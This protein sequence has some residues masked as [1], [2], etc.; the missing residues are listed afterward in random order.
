MLLTEHHHPLTSLITF[1]YL[2]PPTG[3][4]FFFFFF[5]CWRE[6]QARFPAEKHDLWKHNENGWVGW[7][8]GGGEGG[9]GRTEKRAPPLWL[10]V[11]GALTG[12]PGWGEKRT[13][14]SLSVT[15]EG[16]AVTGGR[17]KPDV[18]VQ[19]PLRT[20][21]EKV[22]SI[23]C[24]RRKKNIKYVIQI[25]WTTHGDL[26]PVDG[27]CRKS[28]VSSRASIKPF[29]CTCWRISH[30]KFYGNGKIRKKIC[31]L[32]WG[33]FLSV[34]I[35]VNAQNVWCRQ[36]YWTTLHRSKHSTNVT[37]QLFPLCAL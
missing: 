15:A 30:S 24:V 35:R 27:P 34:A 18:W 31:K 26:W 36:I 20:W 12:S 4:F 9:V 14:R 11:A 37:D 32:T 28:E 19:N 5:S 13:S 23:K 33:I 21:E 1:P 25:E 16:A 29:L 17:L 2:T 10:P 22:W 8:H 3:F 7:V 6:F